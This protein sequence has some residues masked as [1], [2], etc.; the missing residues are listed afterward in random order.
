M[1]ESEGNNPVAL[2][3]RWIEEIVIHLGFCPF[4]ARVFYNNQILYKVC[5]SDQ[6]NTIISNINEMRTKLS[7]EDNNTSTGFIIFENKFTD[8]DEYLDLFYNLEQLTERVKKTSP[9][10]QIGAPTHLFIY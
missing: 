7:R 2:T 4:A 10:I 5:F 1:N 8:F 6:W 3:K 9:T